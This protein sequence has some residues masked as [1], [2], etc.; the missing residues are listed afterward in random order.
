MM[1]VRQARFYLGLVIH[2]VEA[3]MPEVLDDTAL[4]VS[5]SFGKGARRT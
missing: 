4:H 5:Q 2:A 3:T 1:N